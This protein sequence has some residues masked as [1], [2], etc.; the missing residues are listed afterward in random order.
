MERSVARHPGSSGGVGV[1]SAD[2]L[3]SGDSI[4]TAEAGPATGVDLVSMTAD[5]RP[6]ADNIV[7]LTDVTYSYANGFKAIS[8][9]SLAIP[10][11]KVTS[12][13][14]PSGCGKTTV[15]KLLSELDQPSAGEI[16]TNFE[17]DSRTQPVSMVFQQDTLLPWLR[18]KDNVALYYRFHPKRLKRA[19]VEERVAELLKIVGLERF[20]DSYPSQLSGGMRRRVAFLA[21]VAPQPQLLLLD[22]PF[23]AVDEPTR[24]QIHQQVV[25]TIARLG[26]TVVLVT[27]DLAEAI[28]LSHQVVILTAGPGRVAHVH[29]IDV[30]RT[31]KLLEL[32]ETPEYLRCYGELWR[33]LSHQI[34]IATADGAGTET[35]GTDPS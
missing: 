14:G 35:E 30:D 1:A 5:G 20:A 8:D 26:M 22:E 2:A 31:R 17:S 15:L 32:R 6:E 18:V 19:A 3:S 13:V 29:P 23:S 33:D 9:L 21:G 34:N 7:E 27:H 16:K 28:S 12:I 10:R 4:P 24:I 11:G 25:E